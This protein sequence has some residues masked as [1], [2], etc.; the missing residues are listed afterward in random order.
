MPT[1][2]KQSLREEYGALKVVFER[3]SAEGKM[4]KESRALFQ[5]MLMLFD[6]LMAVFMEKNTKK[7]NTNSSKPSSQ[8]PKD[9]TAVNQPG[10]K[11]KGKAQDDARSSNTRTVETVRVA[12]VQVCDTCGEDQAGARGDRGHRCDSPL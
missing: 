6:L 10:A 5:A 3:L 1:V 4:T 11:G 8:T 9:D 2:N 12:T 7:N